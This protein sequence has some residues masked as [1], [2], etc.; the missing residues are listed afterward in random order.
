MIEK[1]QNRN[2]KLKKNRLY[3]TGKIFIKA[4]VTAL[5]LFLMFYLCSHFNDYQKNATN[6]VNKYRIDQLCLLTEDTIITQRFVARHTHL[7]T[8]KLYS[9]NDYGGEAEGTLEL[10][11]I[12][13]YTGKK[14]RTMEMKIK[15]LA[16]NGYTEFPVDVQLQKKKAYRIRITSHECIR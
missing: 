16:N 14:I 12:D 3:R 2:D 4:A 15:D 6:Q 9:S 13:D 11:L 1:E 8:L 10:S 5:L 7:K